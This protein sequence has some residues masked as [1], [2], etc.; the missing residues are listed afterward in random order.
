MSEG[1]AVE[2]MGWVHV[3]QQLKNP[4]TFSGPKQKPSIIAQGNRLNQKKTKLR[5]DEEI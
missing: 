4:G 1:G 2:G 3:L 5:L